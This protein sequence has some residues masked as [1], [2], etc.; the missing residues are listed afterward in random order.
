[1]VGTAEGADARTGCQTFGKIG[2]VVDTF[3]PVV[4]A[5]GLSGEGC[6]AVGTT[7]P[8]NPAESARLVEAPALECA[9][10]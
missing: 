8:G 2:I 9:I 4:H 7:E 10:A 6:P 1:M 5:K 3:E